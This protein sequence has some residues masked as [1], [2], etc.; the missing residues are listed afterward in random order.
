[1]DESNAQRVVSVTNR[2]SQQQTW[3]NSV[4]TLKP[5]TFQAAGG[6]VDP[7]GGGGD[8]CDF[9]NWREFTAED[10]FGRS[11]GSWVGV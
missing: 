5:Q 3:F 4:R 1:M 7:T 2:Y 11:G 8:G 9:C 10:T 6:V